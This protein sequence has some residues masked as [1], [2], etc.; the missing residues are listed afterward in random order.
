MRRD[1]QRTLSTFQINRSAVQSAIPAKEIARERLYLRMRDDQSV[2]T[3]RKVLASR[4]REAVERDRGDIR[5]GLVSQRETEL[6]P[7]FL[8]HDL[9]SAIAHQTENDQHPQE[10]RS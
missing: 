2:M 6:Q 3:E 7:R 4:R 5:K 9:M 8:Q 10:Q 1:I